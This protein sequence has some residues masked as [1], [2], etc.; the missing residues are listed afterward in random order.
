MPCPE[1]L[2]SRRGFTLIEAIIG[3]VIVATFLPA[4]ML[5]LSDTAAHRAG[6]I[7]ISRARFLASERLE[8]IIA[9]RHSTTRGWSYIVAGNYPAEASIAGFPGFSRAVTINQTT[10]NLVTAGTGYKV[11][12]VTMTWTDP[13]HG[14]RTLALSTVLTELQ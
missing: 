6:P 9:D 11:V 7:L 13:R 3:I 5:A 4:T 12:T 10:S 8:D 14:V 2:R 1:R